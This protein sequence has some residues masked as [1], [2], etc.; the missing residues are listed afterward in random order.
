MAEWKS[1]QQLVGFSA[2]QI[3]STHWLIFQG[4]EISLKLLLFVC[5]Q[6]IQCPDLLYTLSVSKKQALDMNFKFGQGLFLGL[7]P[8]NRAMKL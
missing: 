3:I 7:K 5:K 6:R 2:H 8:L 1:K 4:I